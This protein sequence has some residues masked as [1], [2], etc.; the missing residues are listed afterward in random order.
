M[1]EVNLTILEHTRATQGEIHG[2]VVD[3]VIAALSAEPETI[4]ELEAAL[5]RYQ[6]P[7]DGENPF[8]RFRQ[9]LPTEIDL[10][11]WDAGLVV[12]DLAARIVASESTYSAPCQQGEVRYHDGHKATEVPLYYRVP[13]DW[14]FLYS[15]DEYRDVRSKK[16]QERL[17]N[18]P[19]DIHSF[20]YGPV[21]SEFIVNECLNAQASP[22][23]TSTDDSAESFKPGF[24]KAIAAIH[25]DWLMTP[26]DELR[27]Q[28]P[29]EVML[30]K[31]EFI[32]F[33]LHTRM[34]QWSFLGEGPPCLAPDS[35]A[36][37][38][39]GCGTHE[40]VVYYDLLRHLLVECWHRAM[41]IKEIDLTSEINLLEKSKR[42]W[43]SLPQLDFDGRIP[44]LIIENE[45]RRLPIVVSSHEVLD[46][47]CPL[48]QMIADDSEMGFGPT[49]WHLDGC[50]M[51]NEFVF[52]LC[53]TRDEWE[54]ERLNRETLARRSG[55]QGDVDLNTQG[56]PALV[57]DEPSVQ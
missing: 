12:V 6:K 14:L 19:L 8:G 46:E 50:N 43:L 17:A 11:P 47:N 53:R 18:P 49:F 24:A 3:A 41:E 51:D 13:D 23:G 35:Y 33:D 21:L 10:Q 39:G 2:S 27:G 48:C 16:L 20:L 15:I 9:H 38:Y 25:A 42:S 4:P 22:Q 34:L 36:F 54:A 37:R 45:R 44:S 26:R 32:D 55:T 56:E 57:G 31:R 5:E 1:S 7:C 29:R 52:S 30:A 40:W 28:S